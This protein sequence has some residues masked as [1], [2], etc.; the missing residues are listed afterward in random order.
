MNNTFKTINGYCHV[1]PDKLIV[2][3]KKELSDYRKRKL[4]FL[5]RAEFLLGFLILCLFVLLYFLSK[6]ISL[7]TFNTTII[8]I[9]VA[10]ITFLVYRLNT[11]FGTIAKDEIKSLTHVKHVNWSSSPEFVI[12]FIYNN[13]VKT[14]RL[15]KNSK[16]GREESEKALNLLRSCGY[17]IDL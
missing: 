9:F 2:S 1:F 16:G 6:K 15:P 3:N 12:N 7:L 4:F 5:F 13:K 10:Y 17:V 8:T 11:F 14:I